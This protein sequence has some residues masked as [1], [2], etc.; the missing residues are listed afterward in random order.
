[1]SNP[2]LDPSYIAKVAA[3][4][5]TDKNAYEIA[6]LL[7]ISRS[8]VSKI[9]RLHGLS[10]R[11]RK[12]KGPRVPL[13]DRKVGPR[14]PAGQFQITK[15]AESRYSTHSINVTLPAP[16][17]GDLEISDRAETAPGLAAIRDPEATWQK[18]RILASAGRVKA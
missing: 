6:K 14:Q 7:G 2:P 1:M 3:F 17:W 15:S 10:F 18:D 5:G 13:T 16:P 8:A 9:I 4:V 12:A 11:T